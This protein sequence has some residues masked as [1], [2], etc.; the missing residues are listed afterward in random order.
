M[1]SRPGDARLKSYMTVIPSLELSNGISIP[2]TGFGTWP[3]PDQEAEQLVLA[4]VNAVNANHRRRLHAR[5]ETL[6]GRCHR[7]RAHAAAKRRGIDAGGVMPHRDAPAIPLENERPPL[8]DRQFQQISASG[9]ES[10]HI[11][12]CLEPDDIRA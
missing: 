7:G 1:S 5:P 9:Q 10:I 6:A 8:V 12:R 4:G 2:S 3:I 11:A